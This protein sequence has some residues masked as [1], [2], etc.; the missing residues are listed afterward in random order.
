MDYSRQI[1]RLVSYF[2][3]G[4]KDCSNF[5][6]GLELEHFVVDKDSFN[7]VSFYDSN[8]VVS[9]L[10]ELRDDGWEASYEDGLVLGLSKGPF[11]ITTE[12]ACQLELSIEAQRDIGDLARLYKDFMGE[13]L[14]YFE[15]KGQ[16]LL[17]LAY[18]PLSKISDL[19]LSPKKRYGLMYE[20]FKSKGSLAH[21]M[22][23]GTCSA[24]VILD[25]ESEEDFKKKYFVM[26][27]LVPIFYAMF[28]NGPVFEGEA[29]YGHSIR[30]KIWE[31]TDSK[32]CGSLKE[33]FDKD[34]SYK[35]Y[36]RFILDSDV[37]FT[38]SGDNLKST[39]GKK[40]RELFDEND[41]SDDFIFHALSI[42]FPDVRLKSYLEFRVIDALPYPYN[43]GAAAL[44]KS[45]IYR[46]ENLD[47]L[48]SAFSELS[49]EDLL[50]GKRNV[51]EKGLKASYFGC[52]VYD[53]AYAIYDMALEGATDED[54]AYIELLADFQSKRICPKDLFREIESQKGFRE[55]LLSFRIN[56]ED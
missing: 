51:S 18:H 56:V 22:M 17:A 36:A 4:E 52:L 13:V 33:A 44:L 40:F 27:A 30:Q 50:E 14:P 48:Y 46:K 5:K 53:W 47:T 15:R 12:P 23:K 10:K 3:A 31:N 7:T 49:Y 35:S 1:D 29:Y 8:S 24:Q 55:A 20:F 21:N 6:I 45:L 54:R 38:G 34:F 9:T 25:Y 28:D 16:I 42:V 37:I 32:R 43:L 26:S 39:E 11:T 19:S 41:P 2:R